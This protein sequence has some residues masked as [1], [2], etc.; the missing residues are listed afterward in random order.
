MRLQAICDEGAPARANSSRPPARP[1]ISGTQW[2]AVKADPA[3]PGEDPR[4][5]IC[6]LRLRRNR[7]N[8]L[9]KL[10]DEP[11]GGL[12]HARRVPDLLDGVQN[13]G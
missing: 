5:D 11:P 7:I 3:I 1:I 12:G 9:L 4:L 2:P 8:L 10:T 13:A 6:A